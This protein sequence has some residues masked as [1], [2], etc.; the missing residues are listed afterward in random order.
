MVACGVLVLSSMNLQR[1]S[2]VSING[3]AGCLHDHS[4]DGDPGRAGLLCA[5]V[6]FVF[7]VFMRSL[8]YVPSSITH[9]IRKSQHQTFR[10]ASSHALVALRLLY[11]HVCVIMFPGGKQ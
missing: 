3:F 5:L 7:V 9:I 6:V 10:A 2:L 4:A 1:P 8:S 11:K